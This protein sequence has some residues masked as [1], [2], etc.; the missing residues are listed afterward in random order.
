MLLLGRGGLIRE[1]VLLLGRGGL[2][3]EG[4]RGAPIRE[5]CSY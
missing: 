1:G 5:E 4:G 2:I 3:R